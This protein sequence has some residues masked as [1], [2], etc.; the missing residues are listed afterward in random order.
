VEQ[1]TVDKKNRRQRSLAEKSGLAVLLSAAVLFAVAPLLAA[2]LLLLF[3]LTCSAAPF[4][5]GFSFFLP[6]ISRGRG[7]AAEQAIVLTFDDGPSP[8][9][10]P[11]LLD[12]LARY[13]LQATFFVI[14]QQ[15]EQYPEL[16]RQIIAAGHGV[17]NHSWRHDNLLMFRSVSD[18]AADI[19]QTQEVLAEQGI[20]PLVFRPP[21]GVTGPRL[22]PVLGDQGLVAVNFSCRLWDHG[23]RKI[24]NLAARGLKRL[25]SG[26]IILLHDSCP[27]QAE[28]AD[29]WQQEL[30]CFFAE[31]VRRYRVVPLQEMI[32]R[33]VMDHL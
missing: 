27:G 2:A 22:G 33:P 14:G 20:R 16:I 3:L 19:R 30:N 7:E 6:I 11:L 5:P 4:L 17:G 18:L 23:N 12:L 15:A 8:G 24:D 28:A 10:T 21:V 29:Y 13:N 9:S 31:L 25:R 32:G 26:D 1:D